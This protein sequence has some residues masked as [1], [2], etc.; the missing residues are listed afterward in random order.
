MN[1]MSDFARV[2]LRIMRQVCRDMPGQALEEYADNRLLSTLILALSEQLDQ[3]REAG[4]G[5]W[6]REDGQTVEGLKA[7]LQKQVDK[8]DM[9]D[10]LLSCGM[11]YIREADA[12]P[13]D[14]K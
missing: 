6:W 11:I 5:G 4:R 14:P 3:A 8:G 12:R 10:A 7:A 1:Q 2:E 13:G 9:L